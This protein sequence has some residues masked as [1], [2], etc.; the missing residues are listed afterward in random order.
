MKRQRNKN[1]I[2]LISG[3]L[4]VFLIVIGVQQLLN[5]NGFFEKIAL[6]SAGSV[7]P[8][9]S[10]GF[11]K[12]KLLTNSIERNKSYAKN[13]GSTKTYTAAP[14]TTA[15][16]AENTTA[17]ASNV[18]AA[19]ENILKTPQDIT[20]LMENAKKGKAGEKAGDIVEK[21]YSGGSSYVGY[22]NVWVQNKTKRHSLTSE[23]IKKTL[24]TKCDL[25]LD[26]SKPTVLIFHTHTTEAY[27]LL[28]RNWYDKSQTFRSRDPKQSIVRVGD[29]IVAQL[30]A[31]GFQVIHDTEIHDDSYHGSYDR[32]AKVI[33]ECLKKYPSIKVTI[34][35]HRDSIESDNAVRIKPT[36]AISGKKAAQIMILTG[37]E[38]DGMTDFPDWEYNKIFAFQL[39]K[40]CEDLYPGLMRPIYFCARDYNMYK[41]R[42]SLLIEVGSETNTLDEAAYSGRM[43]G[44]A[45][46]KMLNNYT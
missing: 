44:I 39:Q 41:T 46:G 14:E 11:F 9:G 40:Q 33:D 6:A 37:C 45:L 38:E 15:K 13:D 36:A 16:A 35:I 19:S 31:A 30:Q 5:T 12:N 17:S 29:E 26:K 2:K 25:K 18:S 28:G 23:D 21:H 34:D 42:N 8:E 7:M 1:I 4:A 20:A 24:G 43:L 10:A 32:S 27:D 3:L 22:N